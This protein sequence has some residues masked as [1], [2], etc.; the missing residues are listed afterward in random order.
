[1]IRKP[2]RMK[3]SRV[4]NPA[5]SALDALVIGANLRQG[6][7]AVRSLGKAGLRVGAAEYTD[8]GR[9]PAFRSRWCSFA[10]QLPNPAS[11]EDRWLD[12]LVDL[13]DRCPTGAVLPVT[14]AVLR[15]LARRRDEVEQRCAV[16]L[17]REPALSLLDS[18]DITLRLARSLGITVPDG[19]LVSHLD[20]VPDAA[21]S[22]GFP[23]VVKPAESWPVAPPGGEERIRLHCHDAL[24]THEL[25]ASVAD[26]LAAGGRP[27]VQPWLGGAREAVSLFVV[28]GRVHASF[29]QRAHRMMPPLGGSSVYRESIAAPPDV[30]AAAEAL[31]LAAGL[32]GYAEVEFRRDAAGRAV[33]MEVNPRL[34]A[35]VEVAVRAGVDFPLLAVAHATGRPLPPFT[36]YRVGIRMR[37]LGGDLQFLYRT[38]ANRGRTDVPPLRRALWDVTAASLRPGGYDY[39]DLRDPRPAVVAAGTFAMAAV[40]FAKHRRRTARSPVGEP[41]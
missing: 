26:M 33:L 34:S 23:A 32:E 8:D 2:G 39:L 20:E 38:F 9:V 31:V 24:D 41:G 10:A 27:I 18:K 6:L 36:G 12:A 1:M 14:D 15:V 37:W 16:A 3:R 22:V 25:L 11:D 40:R 13:L 5:P 30:A 7:V 29:A 35:S 17:P 21:R 4:A 19:V 28:G